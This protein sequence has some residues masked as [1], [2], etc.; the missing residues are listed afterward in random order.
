MDIKTHPVVISHRG[1]GGGGGLKELVIPIQIDFSD[2][3][4]VSQVSL[5]YCLKGT[6]HG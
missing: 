1:G 6:W 3:G 4:A 2:T 5:K